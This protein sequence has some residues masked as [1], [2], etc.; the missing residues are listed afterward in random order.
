MTKNWRISRQILG[1]EQPNLGFFG[2]IYKASNKFGP[3]KA[4]NKFGPGLHLRD[5]AGFGPIL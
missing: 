2:P 3:Y 4:S 5:R 1:T